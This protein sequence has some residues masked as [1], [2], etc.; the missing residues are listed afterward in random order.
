MF[1][2]IYLDFAIL[3]CLKAHVSFS[4]TYQPT[5]LYNTTI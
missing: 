1:K 4:Q 5:A 3:F 2:I